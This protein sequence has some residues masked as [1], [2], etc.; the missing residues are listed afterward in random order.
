MALGF[1]TENEGRILV[2]TATGRLTVED[3]ESFQPEA[4]Q[5][6]DTFG[7]IRIAFN[8][9]EFE[10]WNIGALWKDIKFDARNFN[11][12]ERIA[13]IGDRQWQEWMAAFCRPFTGAEIRYFDRLEML[14]ALDWVREA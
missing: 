14:T 2:V 13:M 10:G 11:H 4:Q 7:R 6:I 8:M 12:I 5:A 3:Y 9:C 1:R